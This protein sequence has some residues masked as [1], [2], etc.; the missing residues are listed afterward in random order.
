MPTPLDRWRPF[1]FLLCGRLLSHEF[2]FLLVK[3]HQPPD[4]LGRAHRL[5][6]GDD[7]KDD[8]YARS[9]RELPR[10]TKISRSAAPM[11]TQVL[12]V[13]WALR[14]C[15]LGSPF[16]ISAKREQLSVLPGER[17][18]FSFQGSTTARVAG[19]SA[20]LGDPTRPFSTASL[21]WRN[22]APLWPISGNGAVTRIS[23]LP[24]PTPDIPRAAFHLGGLRVRVH[25]GKSRQR[26]R[27]PGE[28][29]GLVWVT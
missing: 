25:V 29:L 6:D 9:R 13:L 3:F 15:S 27:V 28:W 2:D 10:L 19:R 21:R 18:G 22:D 23:T 12:W 16:L 1:S 24:A 26:H 4:A 11:R 8:R 7:G 17:R 20:L 14:N 5:P